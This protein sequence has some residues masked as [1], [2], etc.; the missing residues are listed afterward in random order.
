MNK[1]NYHINI[2]HFFVATFLFMLWTACAKKGPDFESPVSKVISPAPSDRYVTGD[3]LPLSLELNDDKDLSEFEIRIYSEP[4]MTYSW[5]TVI[6]KIIRGQ[7]AN[8]EMDISIPYGTKTGTYIME[9]VCEDVYDNISDPQQ[10]SFQLVNSM[11]SIGPQISF[12]YPP[13]VDTIVLF[14]KSFLAYNCDIYDQSS[15]NELS[16]SIYRLSNGNLF[17]KHPVIDM[18][19]HKNYQFK[20]ALEPAMPK[21]LFEVRFSLSDTMNNKTEKVL[22]Y[23][24]I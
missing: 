4:L 15:L 24:V 18:K 20:E 8:I 22:V 13:I 1:N 14:E 16:I 2:I 7:E 6:K 9:V 12:T 3:L 11:D 5:D 19:P 21:G 23:K 10:I 17:Y